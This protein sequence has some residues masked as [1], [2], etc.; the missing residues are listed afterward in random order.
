[1]EIVYNKEGIS[2]EVVKGKGICQDCFV[3][4][5][6]DLVSEDIHLDIGDGKKHCPCNICDNPRTCD[7]FVIPELDTKDKQWKTVGSFIECP[8]CKYMGFDVL[9][10]CKIDGHGNDGDTMQCSKCRN[11]G[12]YHVNGDRT[13]MS[14]QWLHTLEDMK[15]KEDSEMR[16]KPCAF[17]Y[18]INEPGERGA[19]INPFSDTIKIIVDSGNPGG[20]DGEFAE[21]MREALA[22]WYDSAS[23]HLYDK[24]DLGKDL[25]PWS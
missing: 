18:D 11:T 8:I 19:G 5:N 10:D 13:R 12:I 16:V 25:Y 7:I 15:K 17:V 2:V 22:E 21:F 14:I 20:E 24:K 3:Y 23:V 6:C 4:N 9:T 1:M